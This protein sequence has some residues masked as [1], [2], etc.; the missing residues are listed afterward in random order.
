M[1]ICLF[2][3]NTEKGYI[4]CKKIITV[5]VVIFLCMSSMSF[6]RKGMR[7]RSNRKQWNEFSSSYSS[8]EEHEKT[9]YPYNDRS[10]FKKD[11][12]KFVIERNKKRIQEKNQE[13]F[14]KTYNIEKSF[15]YINL[16][17]ILWNY[18]D[19][20][21]LETEMARM[22]YI[23]KIYSPFLKIDNNNKQF[24]THNNNTLPSI[25][26][27]SLSSIN[28]FLVSRVIDG[29]TIEINNNGTLEKVRLIGVD[30]PETVHPFKPVEFYGKEASNFVKNLLE[31]KQ[32]SLTYEQGTPTKDRYNRILAY[33]YTYP[34]G[35]FVNAEI[36]KQGYGH[37]YT[38]FPFKFLDEF[39]QLEKWAR[40]NKQGLWGEQKTTHNVII[41]E[42]TNRNK[43]NIDQNKKEEN[44][45]VYITQ[46]GK[47]YHRS[48]C[49]SLKSSR[50]P[51]DLQ[52]AKHRGYTV[53]K[54]CNPPR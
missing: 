23:Y 49:R 39:R 42:Q 24:Q 47:K 28:T 8:Q 22:G 37:A 12:R 4:M 7:I 2:S 21:F 29:D 38:R 45:K 31:H 15:S 33:V 40:E 36:I 6:G 14:S 9:P 3:Y 10:K 19:R 46:N 52:D 43:L 17:I 27:P 50:I 51:I 34:N 44:I 1:K 30:T 16:N 20:I 41:N 25:E 35:L 18:I 54:I 48:E 5:S 13:E 11:F 53:C 26:T 32:V